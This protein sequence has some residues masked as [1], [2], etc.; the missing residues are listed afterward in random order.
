MNMLLYFTLQSLAMSDSGE[1]GPLTMAIVVRH[2]LSQMAPGLSKE[3]RR[4]GIL[5]SQMTSV[6]MGT[7]M[8]SKMLTDTL[9]ELEFASKSVGAS[10][11][12]S[13]DHQGCRPHIVVSDNDKAQ[14]AALSQVLNKC[15]YAYICHEYYC[16]ILQH[17]THMLRSWEC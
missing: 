14:L 1:R 10:L 7:E 12:Q 8:I 13:A 2:P 3:H 16:N 11:Q 4:L 9:S 6:R 5:L 15:R 17:G